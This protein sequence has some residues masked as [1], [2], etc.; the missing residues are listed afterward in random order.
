MAADVSSATDKNRSRA[1]FPKLKSVVLVYSMINGASALEEI[2]RIA[3]VLLK[4]AAS[5]GIT[6][7]TSASEVRLRIVTATCASLT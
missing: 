2:C 3:M 6:L 5:I 4:E 7:A 1:Y